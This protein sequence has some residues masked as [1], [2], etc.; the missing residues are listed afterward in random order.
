MQET[1]VKEDKDVVEL[2]KIGLKPLR[3]SFPSDNGKIW[4][5]ECLYCGEFWQPHKMVTHTKTC[6]NPHRK[7]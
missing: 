3:S 2:A 1:V 5:H 7:K 6:K 4:G